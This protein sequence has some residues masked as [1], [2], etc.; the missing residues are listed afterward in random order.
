[1]HTDN[2]HIITDERNANYCLHCKPTHDLL[3]FHT[4]QPVLVKHNS[5]DRHQELKNS[6][7]KRQETQACS[8]FTRMLYSYDDDVVS[9]QWREKS[10]DSIL[11]GTYCDLCCSRFPQGS[12]KGR[13]ITC[14]LFTQQIREA[15]FQVRSSCTLTL[16]QSQWCSLLKSLIAVS[17]TIQKHNQ[18]MWMSAVV[19]AIFTHSA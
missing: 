9:A 2:T 6:N 1:M 18:Y 16:V 11:S 3:F 10:Y 19:H 8:E 5:C 17:V 14:K 12:Y 15:V 13:Q 4:L 7:I